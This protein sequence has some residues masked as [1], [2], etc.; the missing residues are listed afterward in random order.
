[1]CAIYNVNS[2][3]PVFGSGFDLCIANMANKNRN[4]YSNIGTSFGDD[5]F[6]NNL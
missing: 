3:G 4:S 5:I 1:M 6:K 2:Y